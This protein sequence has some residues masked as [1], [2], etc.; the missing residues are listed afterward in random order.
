MLDETSYPDLRVIQRINSDFIPVRVDV[1][2][3]PD[4]PKRYNQG[5]FPSVAIMD[6][7]GDLLAGRGYIPPEEMLGL[8]EQIIASYPSPPSSLSLAGQHEARQNAARD[9]SK[10][11]DASADDRVLQGEF[12]AN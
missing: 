6:D 9:T 10:I 1:D 12:Q 3:R 11:S 5:G 2:W 4:I 7:K 8:L